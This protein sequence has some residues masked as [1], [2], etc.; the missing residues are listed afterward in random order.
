MRENLKL[1]RREYN[2]RETENWPPECENH[3][4]GKEHSARGYTST[5]LIDKKLRCIYSFHKTTARERKYRNTE[6]IG[7]NCRQ[8]TIDSLRHDG[9]GLCTSVLARKTTQIH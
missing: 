4:S 2:E 5:R 7:L 3:D 1:S 8:S 9:V 6:C